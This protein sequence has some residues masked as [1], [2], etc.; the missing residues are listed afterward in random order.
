MNRLE[1]SGRLLV[2]NTLLNFLG[3][4]VPWLVGV[5]AIPFI[6]RGLGTERFGLLF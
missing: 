3:Q 4:A 2:R 1:I 5:V 6:G